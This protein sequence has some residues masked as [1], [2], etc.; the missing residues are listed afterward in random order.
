MK[1]ETKTDVCDKWCEGCEEYTD[2]LDNWGTY[3]IDLCEECN[4]NYENITG[5]CSLRCSLGFG[6]DSSC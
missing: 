3:C 5:Y 4:E 6:C 2:K 1:S